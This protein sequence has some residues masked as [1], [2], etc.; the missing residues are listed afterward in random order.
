MSLSSVT[1]LADPDELTRCRAMEALLFRTRWPLLTLLLA[2]VLIVRAAPLWLSLVALCALLLSN[3]SRILLVQRGMPQQIR[4]IG[5]TLFLLELVILL[6]G[7]WP[8][9]RRGTHPVPVVLLLFLWEATHRLHM[10]ERA[11][12]LL[13]ITAIT[14][15]LIGYTLVLGYRHMPLADL[16]IWV[17]GFL[18]VGSA[19]VLSRLPLIPLP[20]PA[21]TPVPETATIP[22]LLPPVVPPSPSVAPHRNP[23]TVRQRE[24]LCLVAT[25]LGTREIAEQLHLSPETVR[26]HLQHISR[27]LGVETRAAAVERAR[28]LGYLD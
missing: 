14:L 8:V 28:A 13:G 23:L 22:S 27:E 15:L 12:T 11:S 17:G 2:L 18:A 5:Y 16:G 1:V 7:L 26:T 6:I 3:L 4:R 9:L 24:I 25:G 10:E 21:V 19:V 20:H